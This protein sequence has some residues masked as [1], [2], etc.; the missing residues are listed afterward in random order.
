MRC[1]KERL[2][3]FLK[4]HGLNS[5]QSENRNRKET[6]VRPVSVC[7]P[8]FKNPACVGLPLNDFYPGAFAS[9]A[10][11]KKIQSLKIKE[12][13]AVCA[14]CVEQEKCLEYALH[15]E[16]FGIWGGTTEGEREYL[17]KRLGIECERDVQ[18]SRRN[19]KLLNVY[20]ANAELGKFHAI[21][22]AIVEK[23]LSRRD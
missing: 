17:R 20:I 23:R 7:Y 10:A 21:T 1:G 4:E 12:T 6:S 2:N 19:R 11:N 13:L 18:M 14:S 15:A 16:P 22:S 9:T 3:R 5:Y 8:E